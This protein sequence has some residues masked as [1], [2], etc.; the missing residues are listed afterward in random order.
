M[1]IAIS[2]LGRMGSQIAK[3]L[4]DGGHEVVAH[5][6]SRESVDEAA[7][8]GAIPAYDKAAVISAF[9]NQPV[10][11][12]IMIPAEAI[13]NELDDWLK[14]LPGGSIIID[15][16]NSD[17]RGDEARASRAN[18]SN[19]I[20][21]DIGTSGGVWG[22]TNGFSMM[23]GG[24]K[25]AYDTVKPVLDTLALPRGGHQYFGETGRGHFVKMVHNAIEYGMMES[26]AEGYRILSEGPYKDIN[27]ADA[28]DI[29]QKS[30]VVTSWL[31]D[32][33]YQAIKEN[34]NLENISGVVAES[35]EARW[36]LETADQLNIPLPAIKAAFDVRLESQKG[37]VNFSTKLLAAMRNKFGGHDV[38]SR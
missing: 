8:Y 27:L 5:N 1:K 33:T 13:D 30:S 19:C 12:W 25:T 10:I 28:G 11:L 20:M 24:N 36:T 26:L 29:W 7:S 2:G 15:G 18:N 32:L 22:I 3:K 14:I 21:L 4:H 38:N 34:P 16:G 35:G 9:D 23:V 37:E 31:N 17:Y 6:R